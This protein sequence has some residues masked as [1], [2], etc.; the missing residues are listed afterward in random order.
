MKYEIWQFSG[1]SNETSE[2]ELKTYRVKKLNTIYPEYFHYISMAENGY[3][4]IWEF[5]SAEATLF[6]SKSE[7]HERLWSCGLA[8]WNYVIEEVRK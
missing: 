6:T 4:Y 5:N 2:K 8:P 3:V 1:N 7:A